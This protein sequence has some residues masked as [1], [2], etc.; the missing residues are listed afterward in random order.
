MEFVKIICQI[1]VGLGILNVWLLRFNKTTPYRGLQARNL[2][3]EF[4][5][6]GLPG[7]FVYVVGVIKVPAAIALLVGIAFPPLVLPGAIVMTALMLG[8][9]V[10]HFKVQD[11]AHKFVPAGLVL[12]LCLTIIFL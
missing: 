9:V 11:P 1:I 6:Y 4:E 3:E 7:W 2:K 8:A 10:M 5:I 12:L